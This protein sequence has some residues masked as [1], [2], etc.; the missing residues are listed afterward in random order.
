MGPVQKQYTVA[1]QDMMFCSVKQASTGEPGLRYLL[2]WYMG[3]V[4]L[5]YAI[6]S[7]EPL[8]EKQGA[9]LL[10]AT[11]TQAQRCGCRLQPGPLAT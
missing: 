4:A 7:A 8:V 3:L 2:L 1:V 5:V 10:K 9:C 11:G 6:D